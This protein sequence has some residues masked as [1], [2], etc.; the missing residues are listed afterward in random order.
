MTLK[1]MYILST[2][3]TTTTTTIKKERKQ[4]QKQ[5]PKTECRIDSSESRRS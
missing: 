4:K 5:E 3:E 2:G 1:K